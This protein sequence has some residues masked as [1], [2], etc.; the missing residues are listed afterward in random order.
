ML[1]SLGNNLQFSWVLLYTTSVFKYNI[2][3]TKSHEIK[4]LVVV[5]NMLSIDI[6]FLT[7]KKKI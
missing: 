3:L 4:K 7:L 5:L 2:S 6:V 1:V